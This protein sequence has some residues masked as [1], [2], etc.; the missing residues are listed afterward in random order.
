MLALQLW[1][2]TP[3]QKLYAVESVLPPALN[4]QNLAE[5]H[6]VVVN[7]AAPESG[8]PRD[9]ATFTSNPTVDEFFGD[10]TLPEP[11]V[12][13]GSTPTQTENR[14]LASALNSYV[15]RSDREDVSALSQFLVKQPTSSWRVAVLVNLGIL[16]Y[17]ACRFSQTFPAWEEAWC[18][19]KDA[20]EVRTK[21]LVDRAVGELAKMN[22]RVGR[23]DRLELLF[24]EIGNREVV[25]PGK[26]LVAAAKGGLYM[27]KTHPWVSFRCGPLALD[28][29]QAA[30]GRRTRFAPTFI[31]LAPPPT[32]LA[33]LRFTSFPSELA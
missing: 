11:L 10:T 30:A 25:G 18:L 24:E 1:I 2:S 33:S 28:R 13:V 21:A 29:I 23:M 9:P 5:K 19:G 16:H 12:P 6:P 26:E 3:V 7:R 4:A 32:A 27:M 31:R 22:A 14:A 8:P 15:N 20:T 17:H